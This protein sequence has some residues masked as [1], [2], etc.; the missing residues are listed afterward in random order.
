M[1]AAIYNEVLNGGS[2]LSKSQEFTANGTFTVP[3]TGWYD[4][5]LQ[6]GSGGTGGCEVLS[7]ATGIARSG[8]SGAGQFV[9]IRVY[10]VEA[11]TVSVVVGAA[12]T[13]GTPTVAGG[14]GG[15]T[16]VTVGTITYVARGGLG[17]ARQIT[18]VG[19]TINGSGV[20]GGHT[21]PDT[22][23]GKNAT[24]LVG[25]VI[26]GANGNSAGQ[27]GVGG[28]CGAFSGGNSGTSAAGGG[29]ASLF[30]SG[31]NGATGTGVGQVGQGR[32]AGSG[33][34]AQVASIGAVNGVAGVAGF[35]R[36]DWIGP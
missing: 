9:P 15:D 11:S 3:F 29:G 1:L 23:V 5:A 2:S 32:G 7:N 26:E 25:G 13:A 19:A 22:T 31:G 20:R 21:V 6:G 28:A 14:V 17:S 30:G 24:A 12:G 18:S 33:G 10:L 35:V 36:F 4:I 27:A 8:G 16:T 34:S